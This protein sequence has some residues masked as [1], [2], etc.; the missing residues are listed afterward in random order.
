GGIAHRGIGLIKP[1]LA[2]AL[3]ARL[4]LLAR[5]AALALVAALV[6]THAALSQLLLQLLETIAQR[7]L[8]LLQVAH[9]LVALFAAHAVAAR[10]LALLEGLVAQLLLLADHVAEL[11]ERLLH[12]VVALAGLRHLQLAHDIAKA[13]ERVQRSLAVTLDLPQKTVEIA[14]GQKFLVGV[15]RTR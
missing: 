6:G 15:E 13:L 3:V 9:A 11:V 7:L 14:L 12:L 8:I 2:V 10:V 5:I 4:A 1:V